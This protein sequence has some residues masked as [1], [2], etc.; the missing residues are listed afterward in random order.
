MNFEQW[1]AH[2][3]PV[4]NQFDPDASFGDGDGGTMFETYGQE[5]DH[6]ASLVNNGQ[7]NRVWTWVDGDDGTWIVSGLHFVNRIGYFVT[8]VPWE[9]NTQVQLD[10]YD[11]GVIA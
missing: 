4:I 9:H 1:E 10:T 7:A 2:Y 8:D 5:F 3:K 11:E 6:I